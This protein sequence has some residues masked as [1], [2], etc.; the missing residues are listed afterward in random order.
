MPADQRHCAGS[1]GLADK[2]IFTV[3]FANPDGSLFVLGPCCGSTMTDVPPQSRFDFLV[4]RVPQL[5][6]VLL[7]QT[8]PVYTA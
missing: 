1:A 3:E 7:V 5:G 6:N 2:F 4:M 8:L